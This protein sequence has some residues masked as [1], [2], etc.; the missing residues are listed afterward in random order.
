M[1]ARAYTVTDQNIVSSWERDKINFFV[2]IISVY[3]W[4]KGGGGGFLCG[5][6]CLCICI[7]W[8]V[9]VCLLTDDR[10]V[11]NLLCLRFHVL[12]PAFFF[13]SLT[14]LGITSVCPVSV[15]CAAQ[16]RNAYVSYLANFSE[17][18]RRSIHKSHS[19]LF[20]CT[21]LIFVLQEFETGWVY[22]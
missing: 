5:L 10:N 1:H 9:C 6:I 4:K 2:C 13:T 8:Y 22:G 17:R 3:L 12:S 7:L 14:P 20:A 19:Q 21:V 16:T 18:F 15:F 11:L